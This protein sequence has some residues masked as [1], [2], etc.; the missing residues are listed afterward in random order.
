MCPPYRKPP[1]TKNTPLDE[2]QDVEGL[3][4]MQLRIE[5]RVRVGGGAQTPAGT[6]P[7][8]SKLSCREPRNP[9]ALQLVLP[10]EDQAP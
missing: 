7:R 5:G 4:Q 8:E 1:R 9:Q 3:R 6:Y 2:W 10:K